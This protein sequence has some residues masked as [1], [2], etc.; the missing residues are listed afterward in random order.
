MVPLKSAVWSDDSFAVKE[1]KVRRLRLVTVDDIKQEQSLHAR[2]AKVRKRHRDNF[3]FAAVTGTILA[4]TLSGAIASIQSTVATALSGMS[5]RPCY[6]G[7]T[8]KPGDSLWTYAHRYGAPG[9][10]IL[11]S[12]DS[13]A[14]DNGLNPTSTLVPGQ[15]LRI[16]VENPTVIAKLQHDSRVASAE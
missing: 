5:N 6:V 11:D 2:R 4:F 8:V 10:Y 7:V 16:H 12:V 15:K 1:D 14:R 13:I 3:W 9:N